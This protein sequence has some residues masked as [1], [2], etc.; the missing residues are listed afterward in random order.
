MQRFLAFPL[1]RIKNGRAIP[2]VR[3][4]WVLADALEQP[5]EAISCLVSSPSLRLP[6]ST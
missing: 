2:S 1:N 5:V 4:E 6:P 3:D